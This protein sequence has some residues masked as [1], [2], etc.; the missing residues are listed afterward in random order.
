[1]KIRCIYC[2][3]TGTAIE[4][5]FTRPFMASDFSEANM[6]TCLPTYN[7][8]IPCPACDAGRHKHDF[9]KQER[10]A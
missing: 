4:R 5:N 2:N 7:L 6:T 10:N 8:P 9:L 3:D 1:V